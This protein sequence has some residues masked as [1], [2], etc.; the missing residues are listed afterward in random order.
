MEAS[1]S[2]VA[3]VLLT[4][5]WELTSALTHKKDKTSSAQVVLVVAFVPPFAHEAYFALRMD[6]KTST[7]EQLLSG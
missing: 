1:A 2:A 5:K 4:A 6:L 3:T 7:S